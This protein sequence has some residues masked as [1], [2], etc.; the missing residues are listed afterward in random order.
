MVCYT[1]YD[2]YCFI[3]ASGDIHPPSWAQ[4]AM[5]TLLLMAL[6][7]L[8][9]R[10]GPLVQGDVT[11]DVTATIRYQRQILALPEVNKSL[12]SLANFLYKQHPEFSEVVIFD[13]SAEEFKLAK[14]NNNTQLYEIDKGK[15]IPELPDSRTRVQVIGYSD[16]HGDN[17]DQL[18]GLV[19]EEIANAIAGLPGV[20]EAGRI[21]RIS[22]VGCS[23]GEMREDGIEFVD[24]FFGWEILLYLKESHVVAVVDI[25]IGVVGIDSTGLELVG[26]I[27]PNADIDWTVDKASFSKLV[28]SYDFDAAVKPITSDELYEVMEEDA[29]TLE[30]ESLLSF[31]STLDHLLMTI[32][33]TKGS[34]DE[35]FYF[36]SDDLFQSLS[37]VTETFFDYITVP[38]WWLDAISP[39]KLVRRYADDS[40]VNI[41]V[42]E[43][44]DKDDI[45]RD[46]KLF[47]ERGFQY[48]HSDNGVY[49]NKDEDGNEFEDKYVYYRF[50]QWVLSMKYE[51]AKGGSGMDAFAIRMEGIIHAE[52]PN[53]PD[54]NKNTD[55]KFPSLEKMDYPNIM[56][57]TDN[58]F[59]PESQMWMK[60]RN[61]SIRVNDESAYNAIAG[62]S[63]FVSE[64]IRDYRSWITSR[65]ANDLYNHDSLTHLEFFHGHPMVQGELAP[66]KYTGY[67]DELWEGKY[68]DELPQMEILKLHFCRMVGQWL[69]GLDVDDTS[70]GMQLFGNYIKTRPDSTDIDTGSEVVRERVINKLENCMRNPVFIKPDVGSYCIVFT[71]PAV[72]KVAHGPLRNAPW[73]GRDVTPPER[74]TAQNEI[75]VFSQNLDRSLSSRTSQAIG[76]DQVYLSEQIEKVLVEHGKGFKVDK[77]SVKYEKGSSRLEFT[78]YDP[79]EPSNREEMEAEIDESKLSSDGIF[80]EMKKQ[81]VTVG[82]V[83]GNVE[84]FYGTVLGIQGAVESFE[85]H[86]TFEGVMEVLQTAHGIIQMASLDKAIVRGVSKAWSKRYKNDVYEVNEIA[87]EE[88]GDRGAE[89]LAG[90]AIEELSSMGKAVKFLKGVPWVG[91]IFTIY[92]VVQD[93]RQGTPIGYIDA[94]L[95]AAIGI[96]DFLGPEFEPVSLILMAFR[97]NIDLYYE[98]IKEEFDALPPD[99]SV[100]DKIAAFFRGLKNG[101]L[102]MLDFATGGIF[103]AA[104]KSK[105]LDAQYEEDQELL[106]TL[107]DYENYYDIAAGPDSVTIDFA[108]GEV[109]WDGGDINFELHD[110]NT[111]DLSMKMTDIEGNEVH[112]HEKL[113]FDKDVKD[114]VMGVGE[115]NNVKFTEEK[116]KVLWF[117]PVDKKSIIG[118][119]DPDRETIHGKYVG[120]KNDNIFIAIQELPP[121]A[122]LDY[123]LEDYHYIIRGMGGDDIFYL[124]PQHN[125]VEGGEGSDTYFI[126]YHS[127]HTAVNNFAMDKVD[128]YLAINR[129]YESLHVHKVGWHLNVTSMDPEIPLSVKIDNWFWSETYQHMHFKTSDGVI[130]TVSAQKDGSVLTIPYAI[131]GL[132]HVDGTNP[133]YTH[134]EYIEGT[135]GDDHI[136]GNDC[137]NTILSEGGRSDFFKGGNGADRY[138]LTVHTSD[139]T[140]SIH[141]DNYAEDEEMDAIFLGIPHSSLSVRRSGMNLVIDYDDKPRITLDNWFQS[142][143]YRHVKLFAN[144][145]YGYK[146]EDENGK[147]TLHPFLV[148]IGPDDHGHIDLS[149]KNAYRFEPVIGVIGSNSDDTIIGHNYKN[150]LMGGKGQDRL[151]GGEGLD[152]YVM[153]E[154]DSIDIIDNYAYDEETDLLLFP[155][156][157]DDVVVEP[158]GNNLRIHSKNPGHVEAILLNWKFGPRYQ[159]LQVKTQDGVTFQLPTDEPF[160]AKTPLIID[161]SGVEGSIDHDLTIPKWKTVLKVIGPINDEGSH[162]VKGND[163][164]NYLDMRRKGTIESLSGE[165]G[166]DSYVY[167]FGNR[168][169]YKIDNK[170]GDHVTDTLI[171]QYPFDSILGVH[172]DFWYTGLLIILS[173]KN[174]QGNPNEIHLVDYIKNGDDAQHMQ[175]QTSDGF[176]VVLP[177]YNQYQPVI[178]GIDKANDKTGQ[179]V[180]LTHEMFDKVVTNYGADNFSNHIIGNSRNN[181]LQGGVWD[182]YI[183]GGPGND[184]LRG[185]DGNNTLEG[186]DGHDVLVGGIDTDMMDGGPGDDTF[187]P[188]LGHNDMV[189]GPGVDTAVFVG[190]PTELVGIV[191][192]LVNS[193]V[194]HSFGVDY[195]ESIE[196]VYGTPYDDTLI[197]S[198]FADNTVSGMNGDDIL[199]ANGGYDVLIGGEGKDTY[200]LTDARGTK[201]IENNANDSATDTIILPYDAQNIRFD[202]KDNHL[203]I[204]I[205]SVIF[206]ANEGTEP[207]NACNGKPPPESV[208][209]YSF[210]NTDCTAKR[211]RYVGID[212]KT[213][214]DSNRKRWEEDQKFEND[215]EAMGRLGTLDN[216]DASHRIDFWKMLV[217]EAK[218]KPRPRGRSRGKTRGRTRGKTRGKSRGTSGPPSLEPFTEATT[219]PQRTTSHPTSAPPTTPPPTTPPPTTPPPDE[220]KK[221]A[222]LCEVFDP[223]KPTVILKDWFEGPE[224]QHV[225]IET[226]N[227]FIGMDYLAKMPIKINCILEGC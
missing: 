85:Q 41:G 154:G 199:I 66:S 37:K 208:D 1:C 194:Y 218:K 94:A 135:D 176:T 53:H 225:Q 119:L 165:N 156:D 104:H 110:D 107:S 150:L 57:K 43:Y 186:G 36:D 222:P 108:G 17:Q 205:V 136:V 80:R 63:L 163:L 183:S 121:E 161:D 84:A 29:K 167:R 105:K 25:R 224:N 227:C 28:I 99:A 58:H 95:D 147:P 216:E 65:L 26:E 137:D 201:M 117:I 153:H 87:E 226:L 173:S 157:Y 46:I 75:H 69:S 206:F 20:Q 77:E 54:D 178:V 5:L 71:P 213:F 78:A 113:H 112:H 166:S 82:G 179:Y 56:P 90:E 149:K 160:T 180:D 115:A 55:V 120:N 34:V 64:S 125:L 93:V 187:L 131:I 39:Q 91:T 141:I 217:K 204:R 164:E 72:G 100:G 158:S 171:L 193:D 111:A 6:L 59:F 162:S 102:D 97:M 152:G 98:D 22:L 212:G 195:I 145:S 31:A 169:Y 74:E 123:T 192:D 116:V 61:G 27:I 49:I 146:I 188:G 122:D 60:G 68:F 189:G 23:I 132:Q 185:G 168:D 103:T 129:T 92:N 86:K 40:I 151:T 88:V 118:G 128:D 134:V 202:R 221:T 96:I 155:V 138:N 83:I 67:R 215:L 191:V 15:D 42:R 79:D 18:G 182:D 7:P 4:A 32:T 52:N 114:I 14:W 73:D 51:S 127:T 48:P 140:F 174:P 9:W 200:D 45:A 47:G 16:Y 177:E 190:D 10:T 24:Y 223:N 159:H 207:F 197:T 62:V 12:S 175:I 89:V 101:F 211:K 70:Q 142:E 81:G 170:A 196:N 50:G 19:S 130:F 210:N 198:G 11:D 209:L 33:N 124:G 184:V 148:S 133:N 143:A 181:T 76:R 109:S 126:S 214:I 3:F 35:V 139:T 44:T 8:F 38:P 106:R 144:D 30:E 219:T 13:T 2:T 220:E 172:I 203:I 21:S